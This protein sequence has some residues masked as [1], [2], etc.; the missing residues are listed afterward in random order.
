MKARKEKRKH[1][2][3]KIPALFFLV[4]KSQM[5]EEVCFTQQFF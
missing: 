2:D 1:F 5:R 4:T 3:F